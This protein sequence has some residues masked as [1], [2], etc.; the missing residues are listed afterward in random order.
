MTAPFLKGAFRF[1]P[2]LLAISCSKQ[3]T[4][5]TEEQVRF[6]ADSTLQ[7]RLPQLRS[8][9]AEDLERRMPIEIKPLVDSLQ[10]QKRDAPTAPQIWGIGS[11]KAAADLVGDSLPTP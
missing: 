9:A 3:K 10:Q 4:G 1:L 11:E 2:L 6:K 7:A 5:L 8:Q